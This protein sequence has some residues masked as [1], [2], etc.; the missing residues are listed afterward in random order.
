MVIGFGSAAP[1]AGRSASSTAPLN[2]VV[3]ARAI[4]ARRVICVSSMVERPVRNMGIMVRDRDSYPPKL[5]R[6]AYDVD[7]RHRRQAASAR[8]FLTRVQLGVRALERFSQR[9]HR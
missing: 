1:T 2:V 6:F 8:V 7:S 3:A 4:H 9:Q 5:V